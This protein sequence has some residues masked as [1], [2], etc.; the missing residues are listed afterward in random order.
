[1]YGFPAR[2]GR[3]T[4]I[5]GKYMSR[6]Q[7]SQQQGTAMGGVPIANNSFVFLK[8]M[9]KQICVRKRKGTENERKRKGRGKEKER[10]K[11][12]ERKRKKLSICV[13]MPFLE[14]VDRYHYI[15]VSLT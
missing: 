12:E 5:S 10:M 2:Y 3:V 4:R 9:E 8:L 7:K 6:H 1:M 11:E 13:L 14:Q 15:M